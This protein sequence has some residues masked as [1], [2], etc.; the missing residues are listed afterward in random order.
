MLND[1]MPCPR[2]GNAAIGGDGVAE[3]GRR[4]AAFGG[5]YGRWLMAHG[6]QRQ[7]TVMSPVVVLM[8]EGSWIMAI[9]GI[10][11]LR[12]LFFPFYINVLY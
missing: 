10:Y 8:A 2:G 7:D 4:Q 6:H 1:K 5:A 11:F 12:P 3:A 9:N